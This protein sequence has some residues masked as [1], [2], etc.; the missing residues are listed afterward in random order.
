MENSQLF[1]NKAKIEHL[2]FSNNNFF[3]FSN[4]FKLYLNFTSILP[5]KKLSE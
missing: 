1:K 5:K 3:K 4:I 2:F